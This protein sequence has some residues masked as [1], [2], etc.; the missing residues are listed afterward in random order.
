MTEERKE[1]ADAP[2]D[3]GRAPERLSGADMLD[4]LQVIA[5]QIAGDAPPALREASVVAAELAAI[6]ARGTGPI[7]R[8]LGE[9][10]DD[11][12]LRFA[13]RME[14]YA[15]SIRAADV[16]EADVSDDAGTEGTEPADDAESE[17]RS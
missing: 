16:V 7:A 3:T 4:Q 2:S 8:T 17:D 15:A 13:E 11:A 1:I 12:S 10:T 14:A 9:A 5:R 6:A